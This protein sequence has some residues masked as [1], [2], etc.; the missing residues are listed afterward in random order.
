MGIISDYCKK[1]S[2]DNDNQ[3]SI[4]DQSEISCKLEN[5]QQ[6]VNVNSSQNNYPNSKIPYTNIDGKKQ[7]EM[8]DMDNSVEELKKQLEDEKKILEN[9]K[10][11]FEE[12]KKQLKQKTVKKLLKN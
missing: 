5:N 8:K 11:I 1:K 9:Q 12:N 3:T 10:N 7:F 4:N 2:N 6:A